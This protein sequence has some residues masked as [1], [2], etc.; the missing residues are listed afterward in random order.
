LSR[1]LVVDAVRLGQRLPLIRG[2][3]EVDVTEARRR[4][5]A[6]EAQTG[7]SLSFTAFILVCLGRAVES[8]KHM[9]AYQDWFGRLVLFD[10]V[11]ANTI[12]EID[13]Q[14]QKF[15]LAYVIRGIQ[16]RTARDIT[17]EIRAIQANPERSPSLGSKRRRRALMGFILL[18]GF[19]RR[20]CFRV[21]MSNPHWRKR[22]M[23][24][25]IVTAVGMFGAGGGWGIAIPVY[26]LSLTLG[27]IAQKPGVVDGEIAIREYLSVTMDVNHDVID[28]APAA[29]FASRFK[30]LVESAYG[31][32]EIGG[33][34]QSQR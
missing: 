28:G 29:R 33:S 12:I 8:N 26:N 3:F 20:L 32:E 1:R 5:R 18:P 4:L 19:I 11:D 21:I 16:R 17:G 15:G 14:G 6:H 30:E 27:G 2:L 24:T 34:E 23:G 7:E 22:A 31:L 25:V 13:L 9:H 10:D